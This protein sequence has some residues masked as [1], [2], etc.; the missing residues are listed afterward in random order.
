MAYDKNFS[1]AGWYLGSVLAWIR[2]TQGQAKRQAGK[3]VSGLGE[4]GPHKG[5]L[6]GQ[7]LYKDQKNGEGALK[8][9]LQQA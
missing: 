6:G 4:Y 7:R 1:S 9:I 3:E 8:T 5:L 2:R